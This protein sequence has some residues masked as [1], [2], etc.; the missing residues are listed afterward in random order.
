MIS[1]YNETARQIPVVAKMDVLIVGGGTAGICAAI[2]SA[3]N[4]AATM[5]IENKGYL[6]GTSVI[7]LPWASFSDGQKQI[8]RGIADELAKELHKLGGIEADLAKDDWLPLNAERLKIV[9]L[10]LLEKAK[11]NLLLNTMVVDTIVTNNALRGV[12]V[13]NKGGRQAIMGKAIVDCSGDADVAFRSGVECRTGRLTDGKTQP[14]SAIFNVGGVDAKA[15]EAAGGYNAMV[16]LF[17]KF[18]E[19][20]NFKNPRRG[21]FSGMFK[22]PGKYGEYS[23]NVTRVLNCIGTNP[24]ELTQSEL[25]GFHQVNEFVYSFLRPHVPGFK[26]AYLAS[27]ASIGIRETRRIVGEYVISEHDIE[28][29]KEHDDAIGR[30]A[31]PVDIH[32]PTDSKTVYHAHKHIPGRSYTLPYSIL[33][34]KTIDNLL[35][36]GRCVSATHE[37]LS[38][39]RVMP[40]CMVMG[41]AAGTAAALCVKNRTT[42]R[43]LNISSLQQ[44]LILDKVWLG[45]KKQMKNCHNVMAEALV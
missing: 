25:I 5:L 8:T 39:I 1:T 28:E 40:C 29:Y 18:A 30:G 3:R 35:V 4:G 36:A 26:N 19:I 21:T 34:P 44:Q 27:T 6:G 33:L 38:A 37:A 10:T 41:Q 12:I 17:D 7:G 42:P 32:S 20:Y 13:E 24:V 9:A 31:Y 15:F 11:V 43:R 22:I 16:S 23:F 45:P 14:M 2:A